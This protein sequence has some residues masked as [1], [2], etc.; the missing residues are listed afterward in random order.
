MEV[1]M[2]IAYN[3]KLSLLHFGDDHPMRGDRYEKAIN[4]FRELGLEFDI[5]DFEPASEHD[6]LL[7]HTKEYVE[8][9]KEISKRGYP[10]ISP[11]TPGFRGIWEA[12]LWSV[13]ATIKA[14]DLALKE[15][16]G[17]NLAGGWHHAFP[18]TGRG[19]CVFSDTGITIARI[20]EQGLKVM[21]V[22]YDAHHGDGIQRV[23]GRDPG[24]ITVSIHQN[25]S[26]LYPYLTGFVEETTPININIPLPPLSG[27]REMVYAFSQIVPPLVERENPDI[28]IVEMGVDGHCSCYVANLSVSKRGYREIGKI[29]GEIHRERKIPIALVGGGGFVYPHY[30]EAWAV[31]LAALTGQNLD[32]EMDDCSSPNRMEEVEKTVAKA[33]KLAEL[34]G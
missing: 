19:F 8:R 30:A 12:G 6:I 10:D 7:F 34:T 24:V 13:G 21:I 29:L 20:K 1:R 31:Q 11:D 14:V 32:V 26:T 18:E 22:D 3:E 28:M 4:R 23:Y 16:I 2:K 15:G 9:V 5:V 27:A 33:K 25:P 17:V